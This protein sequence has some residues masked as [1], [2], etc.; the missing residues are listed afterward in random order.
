[1]VSIYKNYNVEILAH[2]KD[3][4]DKLEWDILRALAK[5]TGL[6]QSESTIFNLF[7]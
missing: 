6:P 3:F 1:M 2:K 4:Q 7:L 5:S